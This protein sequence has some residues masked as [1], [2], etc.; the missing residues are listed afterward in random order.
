M[1]TA[2]PNFSLQI[3]RFNVGN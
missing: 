1:S 3:R 2:D